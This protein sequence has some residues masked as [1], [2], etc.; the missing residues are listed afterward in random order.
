MLN[1]I[2]QFALEPYLHRKVAVLHVD[3]QLLE[4]AQTLREKSI[5]CVLVG[6]HEGY[7]VGVATDRDLACRGYGE[8]LKPT[9]PLIR[10]MTPQPVFVEP[11][12]TLDEVIWLMEA[13]GIRRIPVLESTGKGRKRAVGMVTLDDL[14]AAQRIDEYRMTRIVQAQ[15]RRRL[16]EF[17]HERGR[18]VH[19]VDSAGRPVTETE[20]VSRYTDQIF[21]RA[22]ITKLGISRE[23][24]LEAL[25]LIWETLAGRLHHTG[26]MHLISQLPP[27]F[28]ERMLKLPFGPDRRSTRARLVGQISREWGWA[29]ERTQ[30]ALLALSNAWALSVDPKE[31]M[32]LSAELP[33]DLASFCV[34]REPELSRERAA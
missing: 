26:A 29:E 27:G 34:A 23:R 11:S 7:I 18:I 30:Q 6:D 20:A 14:L 5:G 16:G 33:P 22:Q 12:A 28:Q 15:V 31:L 1:P 9:D 25:F 2:S 19:V 3:T 17:G 10:V 13:N 24:A 8:G 32:R 4:A 21:D